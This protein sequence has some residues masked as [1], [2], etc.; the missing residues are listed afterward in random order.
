MSSAPRSVRRRPF[1]VRLYLAFAFAAVAIITAGIA[2]LI[3]GD[4]GEQAADEQL[5]ELAVGRTAGLADAIGQRP[6]KQ[7]AATLDGV[8]EEG[9]AAWVFDGDGRLISPKVA[10]GIELLEVPNA[11]G[12]VRSALIGSRYLRELSGGATVVA[13]PIFRGGQIAGAI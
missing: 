7:T 2:Y 4:T 9:Y 1:G 11:R 13:L 5:S 12:A 6:P 3:V 8:T 10:E